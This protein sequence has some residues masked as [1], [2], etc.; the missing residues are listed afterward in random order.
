MSW[1]MFA[2]L[3]IALL[4]ILGVLASCGPT[5]QDQAAIT[6]T[7]AVVAAQ[8]ATQPVA[9]KSTPE[10]GGDLVIGD[11]FFFG[12][13]FGPPDTASFWE[14][15]VTYQI[16][17][18]LAGWDIAAIARGE[19]AMP[20]PLL[21]ESWEISSD[22]LQYTFKLRPEIKFSTGRPVDSKAVKA[23]LD[24]T[25]GVIEAQAL[26]A[27]YAWV[28]L[29][30]SIEVV[31]DLTVRLTLS[32]PYAPLLA[33]LASAQMGIVDTEETAAHETAGDLGHAWLKEH[34]AGTGPFMV[35]EYVSEQKL[36]LRRNPYYWGGHDGVQPS[37]ERLVFL[38]IPENS[39]RELMITRG[40]LDVAM[41]IDPV[42]AKQMQSNLDVR[43]ELLPPASTC[44]FVVDLRTEPLAQ[45]HPYLL[46]A[47]KYG[48]NYEGVRDV[49]ATG[50]GE[51]AQ[52]LLL[53]NMLGY[54][55]ETALF[56]KY[57][58]QKA[59]ELLAQGGYPNGFEITLYDRPGACGSVGYSKGIQFWQQNLAEI[60]IKANIVQSTGAAF[61]GEIYE[62]KFR[63]GGISVLEPT[64]QDADSQVQVHI[65]E[66]G[67]MFGWDD[68]DP[69]T[70]ARV[71][72]LSDMA[73]RELDPEARQ[74]QYAEISRLSVERSPFITFLDPNDI[75]V[76]RANIGGVVGAPGAMPAALKYIVKE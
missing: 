28:S 58:P 36:V 54:E 4:V 37:V 69:D 18:G 47:L 1:R 27:R 60:G 33:A 53:P 46:Q 11:V 56:Y 45:G 39:S 6:P 14:G 52:T 73:Q 7:Q 2:G 3:I 68:V 43:V 42:A 26:A 70:W 49:V 19:P 61:W 17:D 75:V 65:I 62:E 55:L 25:A 44:N 32:K 64:F 63:G 15:R 74:R 10:T 22:G 34:S 66:E 50:L 72:E 41:Y 71:L 20:I 12:Q 13:G 29:F 21:A 48:T 24:R 40:E 57:D 67:N 59:K 51:I 31:D 30:H 9:T 38:H 23:S 5:E 16:Y 35:E 8:A 76:V